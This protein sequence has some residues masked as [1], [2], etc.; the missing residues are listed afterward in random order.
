[1][2][3][4]HK[5]IDITEYFFSSFDSEYLKNCYGRNSSYLSIQEIPIPNEN[6]NLSLM[7]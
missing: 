5:L 7:K 2:M 3:S 1:M 4:F 6:E